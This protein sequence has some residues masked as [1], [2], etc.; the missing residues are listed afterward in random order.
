MK[1]NRDHFNEVV[2]NVSLEPKNMFAKTGVAVI[3]Q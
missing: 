2:E 1:K 3:K